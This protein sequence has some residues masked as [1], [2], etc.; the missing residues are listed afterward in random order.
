MSESRLGTKIFTTKQCEEVCNR[1][2]S[3]CGEIKC[4]KKIGNTISTDMDKCVKCGLCITECPHNARK[5]TDDTD[6]FFE[7]LKSGEEICLAV[8]P[9]F[10][11]NYADEANYILGYL[12]QLGA[13]SIYNVS[14]GDDIMIWAQCHWIKE[15]PNTPLIVSHCIAMRE[16]VER[17]QPR[18]LKY[19]SHINIGIACLVTYLRK[20]KNEKRK[21]AY[22]SPC[23]ATKDIVHAKNKDI[24]IDYNVTFINLE[25]V[26]ND[27][28]IDKDKIVPA[29]PDIGDV[30]LGALTPLNKSFGEILE[31]VL[32][33]DRPILNVGNIIN[34]ASTVKKLLENTREKDDII[35]VTE[36]C[37]FGCVFGT[38]VSTNDIN[39]KD[40][41]SGF[42]KKR[43]DALKNNKYFD[44]K[45]E[46]NTRL[47]KLD[48]YFKDLD[49]ADFLSPLSN[50]YIE[51]KKIPED[52]INEIFVNMYK[53]TE[54]SR[55]I[56]CKICGYDTCRQMAE[57]IAKGVN[58]FSNCIQYEKARNKELL[59]TSHKTKLPTVQIFNETLEKMLAEE[60]LKGFSVMHIRI[61]NLL[62]IN[63]LFGF[64]VGSAMLFEFANKARQ[65][66]KEDE[67]LYHN[68][69][70]NFFAIVNNQTVNKFIFTLNHLELKTLTMHSPEF[71]AL[72][73]NCGIY[74]LTG[75]ERDLG[76]ILNCL[77]SAYRLTKNSQTATVSLYDNSMS[78][79][80]IRSMM[81]THQIPMALDKQEF[82]IV[83][84]PKVSAQ[85]HTLVGAEALIRWNHNGEMI[86]PATFINIAESS[87][88]IK[89]IDFFMLSEV[90]K[91]ISTWRDIGVESVKISVNFSKAHFAVAGLA[92]QICG[93]ADMYNVPHKYIEIEITESSFLDELDNVK[94]E[95]EKLNDADIS[96]SIDDFG[97]GYSSISLLQDLNFQVIKFDKTLVDTII[98]D[99]RA[100]IVSRNIINMAKDLKM[101]VVAEGVDNKESLEFLTNL[102]CDIIQ[103]YIFDK[104]LLPH[105]FL[106]RLIN[107]QYQ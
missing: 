94:K 76:T 9:A 96:V 30:A 91:H 60:T 40:M 87:G 77:S 56:N 82:S 93:I 17:H 62:L 11:I 63:E 48:K 37:N 19:Y 35:F 42:I 90:C 51:N 34:S 85:K 107:K 28:A 14:F 22:I 33:F 80:M 61:R 103:G 78:N 6:V 83:L 36:N 92:E 74:Q 21:I 102:G 39:K 1:C 89:R 47:E 26:L 79:D 68:D 24:T 31:Y 72:S 8:D 69:G 52:V 44:P 23:I 59:T 100:E 46:K 53:H 38:G 64:N 45:I 65:S 95:I 57:E 27:A 13:K 20:Y 49:I 43:N 50:R 75:K 104:P 70:P 54:E 18:L 67:S 99:S 10:Y 97:T 12:K 32:G 4:N 98:P 84:Q 15:H 81:L 71:P 29:V 7:D 2:I 41:I 25:K 16:Y 101:E 58:Q 5:Y 55:S 66:L 88:I 3:V 86:S 105:E 73:V 106:K